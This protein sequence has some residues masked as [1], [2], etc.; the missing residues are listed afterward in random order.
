[1][2]TELEQLLEAESRL[3]PGP[4]KQD[5]YYLVAEVPGGRPGGEVIG[6]ILGSAVSTRRW[7]KKTGQHRTDAEA[8]VFIRNHLR[9]VLERAQRIE[10]AYERRE[11]VHKSEGANVNQH[12]ST[13]ATTPI[14]HR[15]G[16][17]EQDQM[18]TWGEWA[19]TTGEQRRRILDIHSKTDAGGGATS[20]FCSEC[21][22]AW[23]CQT[24]HIAAGWGDGEENC[25]ADGWCSHAQVKVPVLYGEN[26]WN[27][28]ETA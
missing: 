15:C 9:P 25:Y 18:V 14:D 20:G 16:D 24:Y 2:T 26:A 12:G 28:G 3:T 10:G 17:T 7:Q 27:S 6:D 23:P 19:K 11:R 21:D 13:C 1:M 22:H 5:A 4:W 8:L